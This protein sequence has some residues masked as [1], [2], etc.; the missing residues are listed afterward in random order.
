MP[1][2]IFQK[3]DY[4]EI[5]S[6]IEKL[7]ADNER[8]W[9]TM[10]ISEMLNHCGKQL[11]LGLGKIEQNDLEGS[12][13]MRTSFG[14]WVALYGLPWFKGVSTPQKMDIKKNTYMV[15]RFQKEKDLLFE[16]LKEVLEKRNL[17]PHPFFGSL[18]EKDWGRLIWKHLDYH[19]RQFNG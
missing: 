1:S 19:L 14:K 11:E 9:G 18:S 2:N 7:N 10:N 15:G 6:R 8:K 17:N 12:F 16:L 4:L 5:V 13:I 3:S